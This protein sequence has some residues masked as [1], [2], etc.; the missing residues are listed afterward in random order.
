M[1][2]P[3]SSEISVGL[4][5][6]YPVEGDSP[7]RGSRSPSVAYTHSPSRHLATIFSTKTT[8]FCL[9][10]SFSQYSILDSAATIADP[11]KC[12]LSSL[13]SL[14]FHHGEWDVFVIICSSSQL[15]VCLITNSIILIDPHVRML[16]QHLRWNISLN[17]FFRSP[18]SS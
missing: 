8:F 11:C 18:R 1:Y 10:F 12:Q 3:T 4:L 5:A 15:V 2:W 7:N 17:S 13:L 14:C 16:S 6:F 9:V